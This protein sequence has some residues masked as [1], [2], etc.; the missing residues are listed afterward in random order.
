MGGSGLRD[1]AGEII[2]KNSA[3]T[4][5]LVC[6]SLNSYHDDCRTTIIFLSDSVF[7]SLVAVLRSY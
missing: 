6:R 7:Q 3:T 1:H 4:C 2:K 5:T